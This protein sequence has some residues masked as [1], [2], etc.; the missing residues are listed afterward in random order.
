MH[1]LH[2]AHMLLSGLHN[3]ACNILDE[4]PA[5]TVPNLYERSTSADKP[6]T[7]VQTTSIERLPSSLKH[8]THLPM[9]IVQNT[10]ATHARSSSDHILGASRNLPVE[11]GVDLE[12]IGVRQAVS[13]RVGEVRCRHVRRACNPG[14]SALAARQQCLSCSSDSSLCTFTKER[15]SDELDTLLEDVYCVSAHEGPSAPS[16]T[17]TV[18][19]T[20]PRGTVR[21]LS[22]VLY[23]GSLMLLR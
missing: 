19:V 10:P 3:P 1:A 20:R 7:S 16:A 5:P 4:I 22:P 9:L 21:S 23:S 6:V 12:C 17:C 13:H 15:S 8:N 14:H 11:L 18:G 2:T